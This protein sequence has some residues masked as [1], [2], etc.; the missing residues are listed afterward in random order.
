M[1]R[2]SS[3]TLIAA[4]CLLLIGCTLNPIA[5]I[6]GAPDLT[7]SEDHPEAWHASGRFSYA[8]PE[9]RQSGQFDWRQQGSNYQVRFF[10]PL[11]IGSLKVLGSSSM[12]E[13]LS[14]DESYTS[15]NPDLLFFELTGMNIPIEE[16]SRW[17]TG[18]AR[19]TDF[20]NQGWQIIYDDYEVVGD[21]YLPNRI[22]IEKES[23]SMRIAVADWSLDLGD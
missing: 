4:H 16:L 23:T 20:L 17:M 12:I 3:I 22:D 2:S 18:A 11:G 5:P 1:P 7:L 21:Y 15:E 13:I 19:S 14:G 8:G 6:D 10:G 9:E